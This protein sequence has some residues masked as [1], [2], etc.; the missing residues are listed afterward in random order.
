[1]RSNDSTA[2][3]TNNVPSGTTIADLFAVSPSPGSERPPK[4]TTTM[5]AAA[6]RP[7]PLRCSRRRLGCRACS[8]LAAARARTR[9]DAS[10]RPPFRHLQGALGR[11]AARARD[12]RP[13]VSRSHECREGATGSCRSDWRPANFSKRVSARGAA[14]TRNAQLAGKSADRA[15]AESR[16]ARSWRR[17][18]RARIAQSAPALPPPRYPQEE[19]AAP[20]EKQH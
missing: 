9:T 10:S 8:V 7:L 20:R 11:L 1:M 14:Q 5:I 16:R 6:I 2:T 13:G 4:A 15:A 19:A 17:A 3:D 12:G 18:G